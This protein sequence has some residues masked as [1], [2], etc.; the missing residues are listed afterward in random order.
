ML[1][2]PKVVL[3][4]KFVP[5]QAYNRKAKYFKLKCTF[6]PLETRIRANN[7]KQVR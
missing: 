5:L 4:G 1:E 6:V 2:A 7:P 3:R